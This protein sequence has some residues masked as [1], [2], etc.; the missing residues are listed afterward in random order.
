MVRRLSPTC[1][2]T[3]YV[4][5]HDSKPYQMPHLLSIVLRS[6]LLVVLLCVAGT[7]FGQ[8]TLP[9]TANDSLWAIWNDTRQADTN[10]LKAMHRI[11]WHG[12]MFSQPDSAYHFAQLQYDFAEKKGSGRF[13]GNALNTQGTSF[14]IRGDYAKAIDHYALS[15]AIFEK[16]DHQRGISSTLSNMGGIYEQQG[17][18]AKA[19]DCFARSLKIDEEMGDKEG[20]AA[21]LNNIGNLYQDR[22]DLGQAMDYHV[23]SLAIREEMND[24]QGVAASLNNIGIIHR[25][26]GNYDKAMANYTRSLA[27]VEEL[28]DKDGIALTLNNIGIIHKERG[29]LEEAMFHYTRSLNVREEMGD[30]RGIAKSLI[31][32]VSIYQARGDHERTVSHGTKALELAR[33]TGTVLVIMDAASILH[34][35]YKALGNYSKALEMYELHIIMRDSIESEENQ[36]EVMRQ[37]FQYDYDKKAALT[38]LEQEKKDAIATEQLRRREIYLAAAA[39][40]TFLLGIMSLMAFFAYRAKVKVNVLLEKKNHLILEQKKEITD[41]IEYA[42][43]IQRALLPHSDVLQA[44]FPDSLILFRPKDIVSGDFYWIHDLP[45]RVY[46][47]VV[48]CTGHGVPG[49][50][51]SFIGTSALKRAVTDLGLVLPSDI[52]LS[53]SDQVSE[54]LRSGKGIDVKDGMDLSLCCYFKER[55]ELHFAGAYNPLWVLRNGEM[56][57]IRA[58]KHP[59]GNMSNHRP[60]TEHMIQIA[61]GD[62]VYLFSDGFA[63]QFGG[64]NDKKIG[65]GKFRSTLTETADSSLMDQGM[66]LASFFDEWKGKTE[67]I[68]DVCVMGVRF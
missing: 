22:E 27:I 35:S 32:I 40:I 62:A 10:R 7:S 36:R 11:A 55:R 3:G 4:D 46:F 65:S 29:D 24:M 8:S 15:L 54:M 19:I 47:A 17:D 28:G 61:R 14:H 23:R 25:D 2:F 6:C 49:A 38:A 51:T 13:M 42:E 20:I 1:E 45:D 33:E 67:Q 63:D 5:I 18:L 53:L 34:Q 57:V 31:N 39:A 16:I 68:D 58:D 43:N 60:F 48:D 64:A 21:N 59:I 44:I 12:Y 26:M 9:K 66:A 52:L 50:F 56:E 37:R 30:K 41:S